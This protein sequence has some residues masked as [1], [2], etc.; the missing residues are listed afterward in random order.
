MCMAVGKVSLE[1]WDMFTWSLGWSSFSPASSLPR[2]ATTSLTFMLDW[3]PEPV[4]H[5]ARGKC[6][7]SLPERISSHTRQIRAQRL[8]S[9]FPRPWLAVAAA[10]F[11]TAK[12]RMISAGIFSTPIL[13]FS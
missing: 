2:L 11:K 3:V 12:A 6:P 13:K 4:C 1:D 7:S 10:F 9:S 8:S 5:T